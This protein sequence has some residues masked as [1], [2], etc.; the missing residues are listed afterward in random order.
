MRRRIVGV[1][2]FRARNIESPI[3]RRTSGESERER[4]RQPIDII[5][6]MDRNYIII[7]E[8]CDGYSDWTGKIVLLIVRSFQSGSATSHRSS[9][10]SLNFFVARV[11]LQSSRGASNFPRQMF[12]WRLTQRETYFKI[13][14]WLSLTIFLFHQCFID[15]MNS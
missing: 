4:E 15:C 13:G 9:C 5:Q 2:A 14:G 8:P 11:K 10:A 7:P 1:V 3:S 12:G 6:L